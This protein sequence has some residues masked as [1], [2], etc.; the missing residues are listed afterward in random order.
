[1][2]TG[3]ST[4]GYSRTQS[5]G[6][7]LHNPKSETILVKRHHI[8]NTV[9]TADK[10]IL[11][12]RNYKECLIRQN[13]TSDLRLIKRCINGRGIGT[14]YIDNFNFYESFAGPKML[15]RYEDLIDDEKL[16]GV[17]K[18]VVEFLEE[19]WLNEYSIKEMRDIGLNI[20]KPMGPVTMG[21]L[22]IFHANILTEQEH[23]EWESFFKA[24]FPTLFEKYIR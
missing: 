5:I 9:R 24:T 23:K 17:L 22:K 14:S 8:D 19:E 21:E 4:V 7:A 6:G 20:Y 18:D 12:V 16:I 11:I 3:K 13:S 15:V 10:L 1:M 2:I